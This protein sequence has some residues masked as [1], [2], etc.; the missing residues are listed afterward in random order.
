MPPRHG[1]SELAT[2]RLAA[3]ALGRNPDE[4]IIACSYADALA[5]L[6]NRDV[7]RIIDTDTYRKVF[8]HT[9]LSGRHVAKSGLGNWIRTANLFEVV[10]H[11]GYFRSAG[12]GGALSGMGCTLGIYDDPFKNREEA[13]SPTYRE[14]VW[15][16]WTNV[17][18][19]RQQPGARMLVIM[20]RWHRDDLAGRL[21][22]AM[23]EP[24]S[25]QWE[26]LTLPGIMPETGTHAGD[27]REEGEALWPYFMD[28]EGHR[29][30]RIEDRNAYAALYDQNPG[31][32]GGAE[33]P[34][35][36]FGEWIWCA[37]EHWPDTFD[38]RIVALDPSKGKSDKH[39]DYSAIVFVGVK[40]G[41]VYVDANLER[42]PPHQIVRDMLTMCSKY[43]PQFVGIEANQFQELLVHEFELQCG[44]RF[45]DTLGVHATPMVNTINKIVRIRRLGPYIVNREFRFKRDSPGCH[46]LVDQLMDFP[47]A[48]HDD[49][50]DALEMAIRLP[51]D[52]GGCE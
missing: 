3:Y 49:G 15:Q 8:P 52:I 26:V 20:T 23:Q 47:N 35:S 4:Q 50:P 32:A 44:Q 29:K 43:R 41:L 14:K 25:T 46:L 22:K 12:S 27:P 7:Q 33:W 40:N 36:Y 24:K 48:D 6:M 31:D 30:K 13:N 45:T 1:K 42:R 9:R 2:R 11:R 51:G 37:P 28:K 38:L 10:G 19:T 18:S 5:S 16:F 17:F 21:I 34:A 39:G